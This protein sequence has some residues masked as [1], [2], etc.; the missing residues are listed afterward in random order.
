M[1]CSIAT[2]PVYTVI[3]L[4]T[5]KKPQHLDSNDSKQEE[6]EEL[7][8]D[9]VVQSELGDR[10]SVTRKSRKKHNYA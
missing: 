3:S 4:H 2:G 10:Y 7:Y 6:K 5:I 8:I 9:D 1:F